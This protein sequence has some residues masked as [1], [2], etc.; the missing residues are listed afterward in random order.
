MTK[1]NHRE[2]KQSNKK[3]VK[4]TVIGAGIVGLA[5]GVELQRAGLQVEIIDKEGVGAGA[6][7]GNAGHFATEQVFP[8]ADPRLLPKLPGMLLDPLGPFRIR[9]AY[10]F[11]ALPWFCRFLINMLP[12]KRLHNGQGI[13]R[14]N[15]A[16]ITAMEELASFCNCEELLLLNGS[17]LV[18]EGTAIDEVEKE[19]THYRDAGVEVKLLTGKR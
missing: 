6:S 15:Q 2:H 7:Q 18:F 9:P 5:T 12:N 1:I 19:F 10:F 13:K 8:L 14:L 16:S 11:K 4:V 17:L 3:A